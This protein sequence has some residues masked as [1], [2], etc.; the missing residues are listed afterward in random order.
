MTT[1]YTPIESV[2]VTAD[3]V[4]PPARCGRGANQ[5]AKYSAVVSTNNVILAAATY[6]C[7]ADALFA[8]LPTDATEIDIEIF[9][10]SQNVFDANTMSITA[11]VNATMP[12]V[13]SLRALH[14]AVHKNCSAIQHATVQAVAACA[15]AN[16]AGTSDVSADV[17]G[18]GSGEGG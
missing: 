15:D 16:D 3:S 2:L 6:D 8:N 17:S 9:G 14:A 12:D 7:F 18:D 10:W 11:A 1:G 4:V 5:V 13:V